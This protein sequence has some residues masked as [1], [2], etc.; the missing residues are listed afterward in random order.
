MRQR[1]KYDPVT[2]DIYGVMDIFGVSRNKAMEIWKAAGA[3]IHIS[4]RRTLYLVEKI[5][6][7]MEERAE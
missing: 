7:Y 3:V 1:R 4:P 5:K 6:A 2:V